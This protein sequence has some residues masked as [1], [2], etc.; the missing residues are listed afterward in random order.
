MYKGVSAAYVVIIFSYWLLA[1]LGYWAFGS[2]VKPYIVSSLTGP[3]WSVVMANIFA[4]V[5][6][7][8]CFQVIFISSNVFRV[9]FC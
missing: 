4:V 3:K 9:C 2:N 1:F 5:Q 6:I 7:S 8:G